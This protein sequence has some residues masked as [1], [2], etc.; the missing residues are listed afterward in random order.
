M[1]LFYYEHDEIVYKD[2]GSIPVVQVIHFVNSICLLKLIC[3][4]AKLQFI[5]S[6]VYH[7]C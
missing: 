4:V 3:D 6:F 2:L 5:H 1:K 7:Q